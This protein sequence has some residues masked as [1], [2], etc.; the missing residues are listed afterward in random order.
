MP[1]HP[2]S[3]SAAGAPGDRRVLAA[4]LAALD[5]LHS[6]TLVGF[7][8]SDL[9]PLRG[10]LGF[11]D[12]RLGGAISAAIV[13][14]MISGDRGEVTLMPTRGRLGQRRLFVVGLG[15]VSACNEE[16]L[17]SACKE[18]EAMATRAGA[19][20]LTFLAPGGPD[21]DLERRFAAV[22]GPGSSV[23]SILVEFPRAQ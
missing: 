4:S 22:V 7:V 19:R 5:G 17:R 23:D 2:P 21:P 1:S 10:A 14:G 6:E 8:F 13:D 9:R 20:T 3:P 11:L 15:S 16:V 12:W 18:A